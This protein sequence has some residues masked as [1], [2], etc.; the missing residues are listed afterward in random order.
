MGRLG[1][2]VWLHVL[3]AWQ[4]GVLFQ[5]QEKV[6]N[7]RDSFFGPKMHLAWSNARFQQY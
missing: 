3:H 7:I 5:H 6:L 1:H 4:T 2:P